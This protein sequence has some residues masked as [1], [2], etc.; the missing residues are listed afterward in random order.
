ML[1]EMAALRK[2]DLDEVTADRRAANDVSTPELREELFDVPAAVVC[3]LCGSADCAGCFEER[4]KS[5]VVAIVPWERTG[6]AHGRLWATASATTRNA[7]AFF[8]TLPDGPVVPALRFAILCELYAAAAAVASVALL[9]AA[10]APPW[11]AAL[12]GDPEARLAALRVLALAVPS[13]AALLVMAHAAHG[14]ALDVGARGASAGSLSRGLRFGL[15]ATGWD[16]VLGPIGFVAV[17]AQSGL[18]AALSLGRL[19]MG[20]PTRSA[21]AF[22][23]GRHG[24]VGDAA[25]PALRA[26]YAAAIVAT[27][28]CSF[29]VLGAFVW[30]IA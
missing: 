12:L 14:V 11:T 28:V 1:F 7:E 15:Y 20:L 8:T 3:A 10:L 5:G 4:T 23:E 16:L 25:K 22:L 9:V 18:R 30:A 26:S 19:A 24:L 17:G 6:S 27:L 2:L 13:L 21:L 29:V